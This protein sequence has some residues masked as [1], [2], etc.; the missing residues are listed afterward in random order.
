MKLYNTLSHQK[1]KFIP[2]NEGQVGLYVCGPTVYD[3]VHLGN[4]RPIAVFD[5]LFRLLRLRYK[6]TYVRNI[7]DVDDKI[8]DRAQAMGIPIAELTATTTEHFHTDIAALNVLL[9]TQEPCATKH[10]KEMIDLIGI[11]IDKGHAYEA[12]G[13]VLFEIATDQDYGHLARRKR[14]DMIAG[15]RVEVAPFKRDPADFVL[16]KPSDEQTP[17]WDSPWG[18]GRPGW[19]LECSAMSS[20][21]LGKTF[22][23]H[24]GGLDLVFP[25]HENEIAQSTCANG[26]DTFARYWMHNGMLTVDGAKMAKSLGNFT[27]LRDALTKIHGE[28]VR[29]VLLSA[30]YRQPLDWNEHIVAQ[31]KHSLDRFYTALRGSTVKP[32]TVDTQ[33]LEALEDDLNTPLAMAR[34]YELTAAINT[35]TDEKERQ[36]LQAALQASGQLLGVLYEKPESWFAWQPSSAAGGLSDEQIADLIAQR[37]AAR[38]NREFAAADNIRDSLDKQGVTLEDTPE[39]TL[40]RRT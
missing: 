6:V 3:L 26:K 10:I 30:H 24:G 7:T 29:T 15:A 8:N 38:G 37:N 12:N 4:A 17:G 25:H 11:L 2:L 14:D 34:L 31:A 22:D 39:G 1:E 21:Y 27:T 13:H 28:V 40:W 32:G 16:W 23:I 9:P 19:H 33:V 35:A 20:K 18:Y 5:T 36:Q